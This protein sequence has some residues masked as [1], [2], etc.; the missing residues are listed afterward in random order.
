MIQN[1]NSASVPSNMEKPFLHDLLNGRC[2]AFEHTV[3]ERN[4]H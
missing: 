3:A 4:V 1:L 2:V